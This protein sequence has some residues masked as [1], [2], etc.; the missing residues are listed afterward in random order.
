M[1]LYSNA[2][3]IPCQWVMFPRLALRSFQGMA[4]VALR[5]ALRSFQGGTA[6]VVLVA[7][8]CAHAAMAS[9]RTRRSIVVWSCA[10]VTVQLAPWLGAL[11]RRVFFHLEGLVCYCR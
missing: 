3:L 6:L 11:G 4:F 5:F 8:P 10:A 2:T 1:P 9:G 7:A